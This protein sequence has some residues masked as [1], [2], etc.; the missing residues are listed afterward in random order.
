M[1]VYGLEELE[2]LEI[3]GWD[4][5]EKKI[6]SWIFD[7]DGGFGSGIW[8]KENANWKSNVNYTISNGK[9]ASDTNIFSNITDKSY[10][11]ST[12]N[13][14]EGDVTLPNIEPVTVLKGE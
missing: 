14:K 10:T 1:K 5:N 2:G 13:R 8:I 3:I 7:S 11:Y 12:I 6:R 9:T 4:P